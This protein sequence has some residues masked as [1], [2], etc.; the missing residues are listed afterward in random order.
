MNDLLASEVIRHA[1]LVERFGAGLR[2]KALAELVR[3]DKILVGLIAQT[4]STRL[5]RLLALA[6]EEINK[7]LSEV[8]RIALEDE[9]RLIRLE[10]SQ[11]AGQINAVIGSPVATAP[12]SQAFV[13]SVKDKALLMGA[14]AKEWWSRQNARTFQKFTDVVRPGVLLGRD[15]PTMTREWQ[16]ASGQ[17]KRNAEAQIRTGVLSVTNATTEAI[18]RA[19]PDVVSGLRTLAT[20]DLRTSALCRGRSGMVWY[21][22]GTPA[23]SWTNIPYPGPPPWHWNC[24]T[25]LTPVLIPP[26]GMKVAPGTRASMDGQVSEDMT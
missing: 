17:L 19:N 11:A 6:K 26:E 8:E 25:R 3:L 15:I 22:D 10:A 24:R 7:A 21:L 23:T 9:E 1:L 13:K 2:K 12:S 20:L 14:P 18:Y 5:K 4:G 16:A